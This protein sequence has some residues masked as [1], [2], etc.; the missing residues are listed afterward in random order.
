MNLSA[1]NINILWGKLIVEELI[2]NGLDHFWIAPGSRSAPLA[3]AV[4]ENPQAQTV[5]HYDERGLAFHALGFTS[6]TGKPAV[7]ICTSGSA[8][9][10]FLPA[11]IE[12]SK[13]KLPMIVLTADRP[14]ELR[15]TGANQ[16]IDQVKLYGDYARFYFDMPCPTTDIPPEMVLTTIDQAVYRAK[17]RPAGPVHI[18]CM[19]REP[20]APEPDGKNLSSYPTGLDRWSKA[21]GPY[22]TY[23]RREEGV[24]EETLN[25][26]AARL[27]PLRQGIIAVGKL[28][29]DSQRQAVLSLARRL[30]WPIFPDITSG[31]RTGTSEATVVSYFDQLLSCECFTER[32]TKK[33]SIDGILHLGGRI[34][35]KR[36]ADFVEQID[37]AEYVMVLNHP[38]R[39]DPL[40]K[41]TF[42]VEADPAVF[43][44]QMTRR[45]SQRDDA[46]FLQELTRASIVVKDK[47]TALLSTNEMSEP[48]IARVISERIPK[49][50]GLFLANSLPIREMDV[51]AVEDKNPV[52]IGANRGASGIDGNIAT[53]AG[54]SAGLKQPATLLIGD[55]AMLHDLN[56]L[57]LLKNSAHPLVIVVFNNNGG[58]IFNFLPVAQFDH[59]FEKFFAVPHDW[60]FYYAAEMFNLNYVRPTDPEE[61]RLAYPLALKL[62]KSTI[63]EITTDRQAN[64]ELH[65]KIREEISRSLDNNY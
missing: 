7:L 62:K 58:G 20:L 13:K 57:S 14:P 45:L 40:H 32:L 63:I 21:A 16:T 36:F 65:V 30:N 11:V 18:N 53:A 6:A 43:C 10:N 59:L 23:G 52:T 44:E 24:S 28:H 4:G 19:F 9:A 1:P 56:S 27:K 47:I 31:L 15:S 61:F 34:T 39:N 2:R 35:S 60:N 3:V 51:F 22:T 50:T 5:V 33:F 42:R 55:L 49:G 17:G 37:P 8:A 46:T 64:V 12:A 48:C 25:E 26:C 29:N 38:L 41:V 54:F